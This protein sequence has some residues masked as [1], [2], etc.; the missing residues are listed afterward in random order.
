[1]GTYYTSMVG[2]Y[3]S[4]SNND[5]HVLWQIF[6][7]LAGVIQFVGWLASN[8][9]GRKTRAG[10]QTDLQTG[11]KKE[12]QVVRQRGKEADRKAGK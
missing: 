5:L 9:P 12:R 7:E 6:V 10:K 4:L 8:G 11:R 2:C 1:M 3:H